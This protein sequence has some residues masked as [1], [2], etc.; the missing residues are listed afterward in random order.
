[1]L[2]EEVVISAKHA[3]TSFLDEPAKTHSK[4]ADWWALSLYQFHQLCMA[5]ECCVRM[6]LGQSPRERLT[7]PDTNAKWFVDR[8]L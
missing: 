2:S 3:S 4:D 5:P 8:A 1:M 7:R 6:G